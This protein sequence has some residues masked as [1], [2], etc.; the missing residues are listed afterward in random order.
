MRNN[1][2]TNVHVSLFLNTVYIWVVYFPVSPYAAI[3]TIVI[4]KSLRSSFELDL[5]KVNKAAIGT[6]HFKLAS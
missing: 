4:L 5:Q 3:G 1:G 2:K 6:S